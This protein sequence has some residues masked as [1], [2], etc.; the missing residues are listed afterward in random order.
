MDFR[1]I[2]FTTLVTVLPAYAQE[3]DHAAM[4][5]MA[6]MDMNAAG[7]FLMNQASGTSMN[8]ASWQMPMLMPHA[9]SWN[10]MLMGEAFLVDTQQSGPRGGDQFYAPN[11]FM[12]AAEHRI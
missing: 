11:W 2:A 5:H 10:L 8:P 12:G 9:G 7:M 6:H 4:G 3:H 1:L